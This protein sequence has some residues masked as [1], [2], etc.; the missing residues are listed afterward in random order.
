MTK[1]TMAKPCASS[2]INV[3]Q[4]HVLSVT[5]YLR[6]R[7]LSVHLSKHDLIIIII[8]SIHKTWYILNAIFLFVFVLYTELFHKIFETMY[9]TDVVFSSKYVL[10]LKIN[11]IALWP[12][13]PQTRLPKWWAKPYQLYSNSSS[14]SGNYRKCKKVDFFHPQQTWR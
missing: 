5:P 6:A 1:P 8:I 2:A 12:G 13:K 3:V 14:L 10:Y 9:K 4:C 7:L 11:Y